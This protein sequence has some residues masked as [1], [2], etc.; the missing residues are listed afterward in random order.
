MPWLGQIKDVVTV[1]SA[2]SVPLLFVAVL[3]LKS[4]FAT[5][6][7]FDKGIA[8]V[9]SKISSL[10][11]D[12]RALDSRVA[13]V[14]QSMTSLATREDLHGIS[15]TMERANGQLAALSAAHKAT[16][17]QLDRIQEYLIEQTKPMRGRRRTPADED[18]S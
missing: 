10:S 5:K 12:D 8:E 4:Q 6:K 15:L 17:H 2:L 13:R 1:V 9:G 16:H 14:E 18:A 3:W 7:D 11:N